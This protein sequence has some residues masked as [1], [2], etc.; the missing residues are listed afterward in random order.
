M[1]KPK[2]KKT[3]NKIMPLKSE[4]KIGCVEETAPNRRNHN[5]S[6]RKNYSY[7]LIVICIWL[8]EK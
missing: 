3:E 2:K 8:N 1:I 6:S 4:M 7:A 5:K